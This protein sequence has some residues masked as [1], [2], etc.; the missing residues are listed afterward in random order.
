MRPPA[1]TRQSSFARRR[2]R[3]SAPPQMIRLLAD[4]SSTDGKLSTQRVT[5]QHGANGANPQH[6]SRSVELFYV[7]QGAV[8]LLVG[9]RVVIANAGDLA[10]IPAELPH[11][12]AAAPGHDADLLIV[13]APGSSDASMVALATVRCCMLISPKKSPRREVRLACPPTLTSASPSAST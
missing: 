8:Q 9:E 7:L 3:R 11:A 6:H 5:L 2:S 1:T 10:V 12:F 4:S 13:L